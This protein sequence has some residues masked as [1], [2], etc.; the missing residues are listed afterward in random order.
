MLFTETNETIIG[1]LHSLFLVFAEYIF[2]F[3]MHT[4]ND[5]PKD[6]IAKSA[7][8]TKQAS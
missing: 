3:L 5:Q 1:L 2:V 8:N 4:E 7:L 6:Q